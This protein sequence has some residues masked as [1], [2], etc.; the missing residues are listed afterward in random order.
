[1]ATGG[2]GTGTFTVRSRDDYTTSDCPGGGGTGSEGG[3]TYTPVSGDDMASDTA[4]IPD[5]S[6]PQQIYSD[7]TL[8][9]A[10]AY[11]RS[12][13]AAGVELERTLELLNNLE[14]RGGACANIAGFGRSLLNAGKLRYYNF[15]REYSPVGGWGGPAIGALLDA[16]WI[17]NFSPNDPN[18]IA[19]ILH[20]IEHAMGQGH[21][22]GPAGYNQTPNEQ[23]CAWG[24]FP[25]W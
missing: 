11:C 16:S 9:W 21:V 4:G 8:N 1:M 15:I 14:A 22:V 6:Q 25:S 7:P 2:P 5:C 13:A 17:T 3:Y 20:E 19:K 24:G 10:H 18:A 12:R 23:S